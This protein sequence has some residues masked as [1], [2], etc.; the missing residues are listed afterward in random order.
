[1]MK[2]N[3]RKNLIKIR[4]LYQKKDATKSIKQKTVCSITFIYVNICLL[5][6]SPCNCDIFS[7]SYNF[8][9][10]MIVHTNSHI[11]KISNDIIQLN[12]INQEA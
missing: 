6:S 4:I 10:Q 3:V 11:R 9:D 2:S 12:N 7:L 1:M 5:S 8:N